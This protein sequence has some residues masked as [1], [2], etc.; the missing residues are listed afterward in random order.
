[1]KRAM[2]IT[3]ASL[4]LAGSSWAQTP[5]NDD[6]ESYSVGT[7]LF[8]V[9]GWSAWFNNAAYA[10]IVSDTEARSGANSMQVD[11]LLGGPVYQLS[12]FISGA[13]TVKLSQY[14]PSALTSLPPHVSVMNTYA[15]RGGGIWAVQIACE[16]STGL[17]V[18]KL[19]PESNVINVRWDEWVEIRIDVDLD[20]N[21]VKIY[22]DGIL[23]SEG[24]YTV[25]GGAI[26]IAALNLWTQRFSGSPVYYDDIVLDYTCYAD[27]DASTGRGT[28]DIFDFL[29]FQNSFIN[30][31]VYAC[32]CD[33]STGPGVC[34]I[35]DFVCFQSVFVAG[36]P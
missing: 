24:V 32:D 33:T 11:P 4:T 12:D 17:V 16:P 6:F 10:G 9:N 8:D 28:L 35:I 14:A 19:R 22:Y 5:W 31:G 1:M 2:L 25:N 36:C 20:F 26:E 15:H 29:C 34:D 3:S 27:C 7:A 13:W 23:L 21:T 30:G 18:D